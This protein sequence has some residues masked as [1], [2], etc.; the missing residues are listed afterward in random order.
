[1]PH[2]KTLSIFFLRTSYSIWHLRQNEWQAASLRIFEDSYLNLRTCTVLKNNTAPSEDHRQYPSASSVDMLH[3]NLCTVI[4]NMLMLI[5]R[6]A[7]RERVTSDPAIYFSHVSLGVPEKYPG[8]I[9]SF[10]T[11]QGM[12]IDKPWLLCCH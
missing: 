4:R 12:K 5:P 2:T 3:S 9:F 7:F 1:M 11:S 6:Y 8:S 10:D